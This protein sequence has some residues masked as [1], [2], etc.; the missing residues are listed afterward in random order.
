ML[1]KTPGLLH[2]PMDCREGGCY[3]SH[4]LGRMRTW[5]RN[6][7]DLRKISDILHTCQAAF[8]LTDYFPASFIVCY[9]IHCICK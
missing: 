9:V 2:E 4:K 3:L 6:Y 1:Y 5:S 8:F 7:V